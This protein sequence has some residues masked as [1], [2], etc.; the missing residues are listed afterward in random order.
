MRRW[1]IAGLLFLLLFLVL[2]LVLKSRN[3]FG[4][5]NSGFSIDWSDELKNVKLHKADESLELTRDNEKWVVNS[6][7]AARK[8]AIN[9]L[10]STLSS[11]EIKSPVSDDI[12]DEF[13]SGPD[14]VPLRVELSGRG[15]RRSEFL[16]YKNAH[17]EFGSILK[18]SPRSKPYF[19]QV[20]GYKTDP[21]SLFVTDQKFWMPYH[22]FNLHPDRILSIKLEFKDPELDDIEIKRKERGSSVFVNGSE[23]ELADSLRTGR[24]I[25][26]FT[27]VPFENWAFDID[28][29]YKED[30]LSSTPEM[31]FT[32]YIVDGSEI[33]LRLWTRFN[34]SDKG[35]IPDTDRLLGSLNKSSDL[36]VVKY[37]DVDP[38]IK[39]SAYFIMD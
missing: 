15:R 23:I 29:T 17:P 25:S 2:F 10:I 1:I 27:F 35:L 22:I 34:E 28:V 8:S 30:L 24:Y 21:G 12:F 19:V 16:I 36:F 9:M 14:L 4:K 5:S 33:N 7:F 13:V 31:E 18:L 38:I 32:L 11:L 20:P 39:S 26:Y 3:P 6:S 37:F